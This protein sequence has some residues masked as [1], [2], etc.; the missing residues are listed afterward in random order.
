[1]IAANALRDFL[2][3]M[4]KGDLVIF[5]NPS[6]KPHDYIHLHDSI[7]KCT[8]LSWLSRLCIT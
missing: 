4:Y 3:E 2:K 8:D 1:M 7:P 5:G 6:L